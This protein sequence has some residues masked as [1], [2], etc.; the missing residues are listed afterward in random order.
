MQEKMN[1]T[2]VVKEEYTSPVVEMMVFV[3]DD[4]VVTSAGNGDVQTQESGAR[5]LSD[6]ALFPGNGKLPAGIFPQPCSVV[7][8]AD[9]RVD[10]GAAY[11]RQ[12]ERDHAQ[13]HTGEIAGKSL[14]VQEH[15]A[16]FYDSD[17]PGPGWVHGG[18]SL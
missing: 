8:R 4:I 12:P 9:H 2:A 10:P 16:V 6:H 1:G 15:D 11:G 5:H 13:Q 7:R 17:R 18:Q 3:D 14:R